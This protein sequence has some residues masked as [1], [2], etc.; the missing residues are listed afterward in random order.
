M[1]FQAVRSTLGLEVPVA[2]TNRL[3]VSH[4]V[5]KVVPYHH[6]TLNYIHTCM[7]Y[8]GHL[9]DLV[10]TKMKENRERTDRLVGQFYFCINFVLSNFFFKSQSMASTVLLCY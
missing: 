9:A 3:L 1:S 5:C 6:L 7:Q 2:H 10:G 4:E 8:L